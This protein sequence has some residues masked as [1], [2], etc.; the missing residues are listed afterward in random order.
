MSGKT[1][2]EIFPLVKIFASL[3]NIG[4]HSISSVKIRLHTLQT[5]IFCKIFSNNKIDSLHFIAICEFDLR[6]CYADLPVAT[7]VPMH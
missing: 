6:I 2:T 5:T 3:N 1:E 4:A 7:S